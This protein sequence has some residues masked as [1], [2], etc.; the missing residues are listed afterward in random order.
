MEEMKNT[1]KI[2]RSKED[3]RSINRK[4][5]NS[6]KKLSSLKDLI[7]NSRV[8]VEH[9]K[10]NSHR[11]DLYK[12]TYQKLVIEVRKLKIQLD[13]S[14]D[15]DNKKLELLHTKLTKL[16]ELYEYIKKGSVHNFIR[17]ELMKK[18]VNINETMLHKIDINKLL[19]QAEFSK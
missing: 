7:V 17:T 10:Q 4:I 15:I 18:L 12:E 13:N 2:L 16:G 3:S 1:E 11:N 9:I 5:I 19:L 14:T 6:H 8:L